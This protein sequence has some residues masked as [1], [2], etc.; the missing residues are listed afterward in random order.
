MKRFKFMTLFAL[1]M[2]SVSYFTD[3]SFLESWDREEFSSLFVNADGVNAEGAV[4]DDV[5][6]PYMY[7][8]G[9]IELEEGIVVGKDICN[10]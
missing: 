4:I 1:V 8:N 10:R 9:Y 2:Y 5:V 3:S 7:T 6:N